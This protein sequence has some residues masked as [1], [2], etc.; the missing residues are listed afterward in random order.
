M[1]KAT[2]EEFRTLGEL[3]EDANAIVAEVER[4]KRPIVITKKGKPSVVVMDV[5]SYQKQLHLLNLSRLLNEAEAELRA[6]KGRPIEEF[7]A[8]LDR[9]EKASRHH[10]AKRRA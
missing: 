10:R 8:E 9:E 6:G 5:A 7:F 1:S 3:E 2:G 4:S